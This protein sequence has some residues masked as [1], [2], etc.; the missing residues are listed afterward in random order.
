M[1]VASFGS[2]FVV[3][4]F[5]IVLAFDRVIVMAWSSGMTPPSAELSRIAPIDLPIVGVEI[6]G[7]I[8]LNR[9]DI[10]FLS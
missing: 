10:D 9:V 8:T 4:E 3:G 5:S 2:L 6:S 7:R 1:L